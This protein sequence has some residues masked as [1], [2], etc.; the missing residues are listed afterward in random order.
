LFPIY[1]QQRSPDPGLNYTAV[2]PFYGRLENRLF[3]DEIRFVLFPLYGQSRKK[4]VVTDNYL[5]PFFHVRHG[6]ALQG[7]QFW[8]LAGYDTKT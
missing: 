4:D 1:F 5:Y 7:W 3:R 6:D 8:P 2:V